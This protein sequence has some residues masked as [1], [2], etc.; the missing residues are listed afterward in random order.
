MN[1][2]DEYIKKL[3]SE[4]ATIIQEEPI[5][6]KSGRESH[7]YINH[8]NFIC[9]PDNLKLIISLFQNCLFA[10]S[11][12]DFAICNVPSSVSPIL[13]GALSLRLNRPFYF[14]R[15]VSGEKGLYQ[16]IFTYDFN[17]S[18]SFVHKL[19]AVIIDDVVTTSNTIKMTAQSLQNAGINILC[20]V[21]IVDRRVKSEKRDNQ[22]KIISIVTLEEILNYGMDNLSLSRE[23]K[24]LIDIELQHLA[25]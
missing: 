13:I 15:P 11:H 14:Y 12:Q 19:P 17:P 16:D 10:I 7:S 18:S 6:L 23:Q 4:K 1:S 8:R 24:K 9:L 25:M 5:I 21:A 2:K 20:C 3:W 22:I